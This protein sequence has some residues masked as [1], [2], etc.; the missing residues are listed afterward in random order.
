M[1]FQDYALFPHLT[2][3]ANV[4]FGLRGE[5]RSETARRVRELLERVGLSRYSS[6]YPHALSGGERQ[7]VALARALAP[8]P[9][10]LLM[11]EPFSSLD[12]GLRERV[13][14]D[15]L[16]VLRD[17][18]TTTIIVT[19]DAT[20]AVRLA[21]RIALLRGGR[22]LQCGS[23]EELYTRPTTAFAA[24]FLGDVNELAGTCRNGRV[25]TALG[26]F[27][28]PQLPEQTPARVCI[29]PQ[30]LRMAGAPTAIKG[31]V[32]A[33]EFLGEIERVLVNVDHLRTPV[34]VRLLGRTQLAPGDTVHLAVDPSDVVVVPDDGSSMDSAM[35]SEA[36]R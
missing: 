16:N 1:V 5:N 9:R 2:V 15:T 29:R 17:T 25:E 24:H 23:P 36:L 35:R 11:D 31:R 34:S 18:N 26:S 12:P 7:R 19:H 30:H 32:L 14:R 4:A 22:L 20:E 27:A 21:D 8:R 3:E 6:S 28:A 10:V 13:R 33:S